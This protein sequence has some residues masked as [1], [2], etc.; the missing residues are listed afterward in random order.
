MA[1]ALIAAMLSGTFST[2]FAEET[3]QTEVLEEA[4]TTEETEEAVEEETAAETEEEPQ[5]ADG[6]DKESGTGEMIAEVESSSGS[7]VTTDVSQIVENC[8]PSIVAITNISVEEVESYYY[9]TMEY[10]AESTASGIIIDQNEEE[11]LIATNNHVVSNAK[12][13][14]VCFSVEAEDPDDL[15][16]PA[17]LKGSDSVYELAVIA[18]QK[19]DIPDDV[20][21]QLRIAKLGSSEDLKVGQAAI[22]IGN[23]LGYGQSVTVGVIS[24]LDRPLTIDNFS[25]DVILTDAAINFGNSGSALLNEDGELIGICVAKENNTYAE[26]MGYAI[27]IDTAIPVLDVMVSKDTRDKLSDA[28]R[29]YIGATVLEVSEEAS[30]VYG[31]PGGA[32][33]YEVAEGS[34]AEAAGIQDGDIITKIQ[35]ETVTGSSDLIEKMSY[36]APGETITLE[37]QTAN[38]G[39]YEA[40]DVDVTLEKGD[41]TEEET[42]EPD[43][44]DMDEEAPEDY[45][46]DQWGD[47]FYYFDDDFDWYNDEFSD[48]FEDY[49]DQFSMNF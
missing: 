46:S 12:E 10:E 17:K 18:V 41:V 43:E 36:Y 13:L 29:G 23:A 47:P 20:L 44:E 21:A 45:D 7:I 24:A 15:V 25:M 11:I 39:T 6:Q 33:V 27:P 35:G 16:V 4:Q 14:T 3:D 2:A 30:D 1:L 34:P 26:G 42:E 40:R 37:V 28:S 9:G 5:T 49:N 31:M 48:G 19:E 32:F 22:A 38:N 8:M